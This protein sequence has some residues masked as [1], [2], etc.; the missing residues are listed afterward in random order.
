[1]EECECKRPR[2]EQQQQQQMTSNQRKKCFFGEAG[3]AATACIIK[4][5]YSPKH[6]NV[7]RW[8]WIRSRMH[9][10]V[11][12]FAGRTRVYSYRPNNVVCRWIRLTAV[13]DAFFRY[14]AFAHGISDFVCAD[15]EKKKR[16]IMCIFIGVLHV[17]N[18]LDAHVRI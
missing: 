12:I 2:Q 5:L 18:F 3:V 4:Y 16:R 9:A 8:K 11:F 10:R 13:A 1:M 17:L 6:V 7:K 14:S 15:E